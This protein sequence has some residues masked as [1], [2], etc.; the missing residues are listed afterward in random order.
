MVKKVEQHRVLETLQQMK[1]DAAA[2]MNILDKSE[3]IRETDDQMSSVMKKMQHDKFERDIKE[4]EELKKSKGK[5]ASIFN[6]QNK[7]LGSKRV[8]RKWSQL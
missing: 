4:L 5:S 3:I 7:V 2:E 6:L 8:L 1:L